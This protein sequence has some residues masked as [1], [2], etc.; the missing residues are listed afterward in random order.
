M[1]TLDP[2]LQQDTL[3]LGDFP[4][5]SLLLMND[6]QYPWFIL[7][8]RREDVTEVFQ[9]ADAEERQ[10]WQE[11]S[12]LAERLKDSFKADKMNI[13]TLG[14]VVSQ[15]HVHVI[16]RSR[17]DVA[18]PAPV[19]GHKPAVP[20]SEEQLAALRDKLSMVLASLDFSWV[21]TPA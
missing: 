2:R 15:L 5:C 14:N 13:A 8:P 21:E 1:F 16:A 4:L 6:S 19:W 12:L 11:A 7:V 3:H 9:L 17:K 18:W 10:L 20:Y